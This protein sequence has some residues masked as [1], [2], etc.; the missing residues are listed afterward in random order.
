MVDLVSRILKEPNFFFPTSGDFGL[1]AK[2][3]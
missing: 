2:R 3:Y 1:V